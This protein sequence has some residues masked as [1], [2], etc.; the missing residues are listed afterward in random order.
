[1]VK[2]LIIKLTV[3]HAHTVLPS[4]LFFYLFIYLSRINLGL[5]LERPQAKEKFLYGSSV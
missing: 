2:I 5:F 4:G 3:T 1:M